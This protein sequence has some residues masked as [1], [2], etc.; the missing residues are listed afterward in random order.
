[1]PGTTFAGQKA[2]CS[3]SAKKILGVAV[4]D[5][6]SDNLQRHELF[7]DELGCVEHIEVK[8]R[9]LLFVEQLNTEIPFRKIAGCDR[10]KQIA[11]M[12]VGVGATNL[13]G[14]VPDYRLH[15]ELRPPVELDKARFAFGIDEAKRIDAKSF[16]HAQ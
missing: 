15:A 12:E 5:H 8:A 10:L 3:V 2:I 6:P 4:E 1:M 7:G 11:A 14:F 16:D 13:Y 9:G